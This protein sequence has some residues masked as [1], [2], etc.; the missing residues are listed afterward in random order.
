MAAPAKQATKANLVIIGHYNCP[1]SYASQYAAA[2]GSNAMGLTSFGSSRA[3]IAN[4][5]TRFLVIILVHL[6]RFAV[7]TGS[8]NVTTSLI[9][10]ARWITARASSAMAA[11]SCPSDATTAAALVTML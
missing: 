3:R 5:G 9:L 10:S 11:S 7:L 4:V 1:N 6:A 2:G 8:S